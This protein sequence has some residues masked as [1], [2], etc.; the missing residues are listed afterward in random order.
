MERDM[1]MDP[2][3][4]LEWGLIDEVIEFRPA[5]LMPEGLSGGDS[6]QLGGGGGGGNGNGRGRDMEEPSAV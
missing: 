5:S 1:F 3:E 4:A 6:P 2:E